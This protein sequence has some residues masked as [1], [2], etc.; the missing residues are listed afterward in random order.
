MESKK[1]KDYKKHF[2][3]ATNC[4]PDHSFEKVYIVEMIS[5]V[6]VDGKKAYS[7]IIHGD[8]IK[9]ISLPP[10]CGYYEGQLLVVQKVLE[11]LI[12]NDKNCAVSFYG[13]GRMVSDWWYQMNWSCRVPVWENYKEVF[14]KIIKYTVERKIMVSMSD[15]TY[16]PYDYKT[17]PFF[18]NSIENYNK[19]KANAVFEHFTFMLSNGLKAKWIKDTITQE[20]LDYFLM[21]QNLSSNRVIHISKAMDV[22]KLLKTRKRMY[23][24]TTYIN[25]FARSVRQPVSVGLKKFYMPFLIKHEVDISRDFPFLIYVS[26]RI[27]H[28]FYEGFMTGLYSN[29]NFRTNV[30]KRELWKLK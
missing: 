20:E 26:F 22:E 3:A 9:Q 23:D 18:H 15:M 29:L 11:W 1:F 24:N 17:H 28:E 27:S 6:L 12:S 16:Q 7:A 25:E 5:T 4:K 10:E 14:M 2:L 13:I 21:F 30:L 19:L 8:R